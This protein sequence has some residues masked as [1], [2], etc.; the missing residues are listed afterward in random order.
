M[1]QTPQKINLVTNY[2][3]KEEARDLREARGE[4]KRSGKGQ[5]FL[6]NWQEQIKKG[7]TVTARKVTH[8]R[9]KWESKR[10]LT[11]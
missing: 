4:E 5:I 6:Q 3:Q 9:N 1:G 11:Q 7:Q 8:L 2:H 10:V